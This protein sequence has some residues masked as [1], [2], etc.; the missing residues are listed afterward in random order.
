M[1]AYTVLRKI[2]LR[3]THRPTGNTR[4]YHSNVE[5]PP[6]AVLTIARYENETGYYLLYFDDNDQEMT[7]TYHDTLD[8][9]LAQAEFEYGVRPDEW[10]LTHDNN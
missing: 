2:R 9:A 6:A 7:D 5:L 3:P 10:Q 4:H 1:I 8:D